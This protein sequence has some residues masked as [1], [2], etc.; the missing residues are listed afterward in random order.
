M[1]DPVDISEGTYTIWLGLNAF[2]KDFL[3]LLLIPV[4]IFEFTFKF[5][6]DQQLLSVFLNF[7]WISFVVNEILSSD[8]AEA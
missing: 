4:Q 3:W 7:E 1:L 2:L 5:P 8:F 6:H